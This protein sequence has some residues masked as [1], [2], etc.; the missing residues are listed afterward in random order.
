MIIKCFV[1]VR[2]EIENVYVVVL[3]FIEFLK[4]FENFVL[5]GYNIILFDIFVFFYKL[6]EFYLLN[7]FFLIVYFCIDIL[8]LF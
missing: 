8:K 2:V 7:E 1:K 6:S 4:G 5:V 3:D